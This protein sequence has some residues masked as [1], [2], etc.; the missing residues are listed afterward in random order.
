MEIKLKNEVFSNGF[1]QVLQGLMSRKMTPATSY[2]LGKFADEIDRN[3][4]IYQ[5]ALVKVQKEFAKL[6]KDGELVRLPVC[7]QCGE[8]YPKGNKK[9][10]CV[11]KVRGQVC[12]GLI[13]VDGRLDIPEKNVAKSKE[14][15]ADLQSVEET[16]NLLKKVKLDDS[17]KLTPSEVRLIGDILDLNIEE[18][19]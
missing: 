17:E 5:E 15:F 11:A 12:S 1:M 3:A 16:Y 18:E 7:P 4:K 14:A 2:V 19:K 10:T 13:V 8:A 9:K 6:D